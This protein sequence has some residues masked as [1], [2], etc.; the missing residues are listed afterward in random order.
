MFIVEIA[1]GNIVDEGDAL[2]DAYTDP[3]LFTIVATPIPAGM[4]LPI[5]NNIT[6]SWQESLPAADIAATQ[7][8]AI[9]N[10]TPAA[11]A[12]AE[13]LLAGDIGVKVKPAT[14]E[15]V[16]WL[17]TYPIASLAALPTMPISTFTVLEGVPSLTHVLGVVTSSED[18]V[19]A[20]DCYLEVINTSV[21]LKAKSTSVMVQATISVDG[22]VKG[23][24]KCPVR[25]ASRALTLGAVSST[26]R[27]L[28]MRL[29]VGSALTAQCILV[30]DDPAA[31][32][33]TTTSATLEMQLTEL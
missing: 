12:A 10:A 26:S 2:H 1:T 8:A 18:A 3:L 25:F 13:P 19:Y 23:I 14:I 30:N 4:Y 31:M 33:Q 5:W 21:A 11:Q 16:D 17:Q 29:P 15:I 32:A 20:V 24:I 9:F 6:V 22:I 27:R 7:Q 28:T